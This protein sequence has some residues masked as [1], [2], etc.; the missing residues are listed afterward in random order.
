MKPFLFAVALASCFASAQSMTV[1]GGNQIPWAFVNGNFAGKLADAR[2]DII[3]SQ[4]D[5]ELYSNWQLGFGDRV[6]GTI[7][8][9]DFCRQQLIAINLGRVNTFNRTVEVR[10][11]K[12]IGPDIWEVRVKVGSFM[13]TASS[14]SIFSPYTVIVTPYGPNNYDFVFDT[15]EGQEILEVRSAPKFYAIP[16]GW[17]KTPPPSKPGSRGR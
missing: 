11:I 17:W 4:Y 15:P 2:V 14:D 16:E 5:W 10:S 9:P 13:G 3:R 7:F 12:S 8:T 1:F 6:T